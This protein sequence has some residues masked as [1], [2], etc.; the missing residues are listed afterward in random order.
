MC[1][2][3]GRALTADPREPKGKKSINPELGSPG[4]ETSVVRKEHLKLKR[5]RLW[6]ALSSLDG[7]LG[8]FHTFNELS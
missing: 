1:W 7:Y 8:S 5:N 3:G 4:A 6:L 2:K